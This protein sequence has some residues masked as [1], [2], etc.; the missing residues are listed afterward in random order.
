M[1]ADPDGFSGILPNPSRIK[2]KKNGKFKG[3][4]DLKL[5]LI[6]IRD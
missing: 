6:F 1:P 4:Q 2:N 3:S 5:P